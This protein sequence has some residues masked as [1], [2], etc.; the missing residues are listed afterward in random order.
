M[1]NI[2]K[3][4]LIAIICGLIFFVLGFPCRE[5]FKISETTEVRIVAA[6]PLRFGLSLG[7]AG[8]LGCAIA[9]LIADIMSGYDAIIFIPGFF[10]QIIYGYVP[11]V[12]WNRLRKNDKNKFKL[13]K[14][15][16]N[17]QYMLIVILDSLA[18]AVMVVSVIKLKYDE[19]YL[20]MLSANIFFNQFITMVVIGFPYLI[21]ASLI[22]QRKMRK[23]LHKPVTYVINFSLNEK[24]IL[25]FLTTCIIISVAIGVA[26]YPSIELKYGENNL[27]L[28]NYV[29]FFIG[30]LLNIGIWVSLG[31]LYYMERTVTKPIESMSEIAKTFGQNTDIYERIH[32]TLQK[33]HQYIYFT[34]EVGKL[35]RSYEEMAKE[36]DDY[37]KNLT[38]ATAKQQKV[39]TELSIATA[40]QRA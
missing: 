22:R 1:K 20:S 37:V 2:H 19:Q 36:L 28:W 14:I 29:Y 32:N 23:Q 18:S 39:H 21:C 3:Y 40:I 30:S 12:I 38:E 10:V 7:F 35:A 5:F 9:N 11:A 24:F 6:L 34:S 13:D 4:I 8:V 17:V 25:F 31:F 26:S 27:Y 33:C 15:Y 16:K